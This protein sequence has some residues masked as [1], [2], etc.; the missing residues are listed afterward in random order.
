MQLPQNFRDLAAEFP[1]NLEVRRILQLTSPRQERHWKFI[2]ASRS[3]FDRIP[4]AMD[5]DA[6]FYRF[7]SK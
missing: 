2:R 7:P 6:L 4:A 3:V 1:H 5:M